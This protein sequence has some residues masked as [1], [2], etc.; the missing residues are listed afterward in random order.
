MKYLIFI[1]LTFLSAAASAFSPVDCSNPRNEA[2]LYVC[3]D[4]QLSELNNQSIVLAID[5][6]GKNSYQANALEEQFQARVANCNF[7]QTCWYQAYQDLIA[8][9]EELKRQYE[10][11]STAPEKSAKSDDG[12]W[13]SFASYFMIFMIILLAI[14][15]LPTIIAFNRDHRHR[16]VILIVNVVF[17]CTLLGW[18]VA[19]VWA[20][21]KF[22]SPVKGG[23]KY[24]PQP[25]DPSI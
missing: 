11:R 19:L 25:H 18:L 17:G 24:D 14:Y 15:F 6:A 23:N 22:D 5:V 7:S 2:Q 16:W 8:G 4:A 12:F 3:Q 21:N 20:L 1:A 10:Q 9:Y 13:G